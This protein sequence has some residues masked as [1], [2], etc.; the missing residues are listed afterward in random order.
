MLHLEEDFLNQYPVWDRLRATYRK[1]TARELAKLK[2]ES[3]LDLELAGLLLQD[4]GLKEH[5]RVL[6][7][8]QD[9]V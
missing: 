7:S 3:M 1:Y 5:L 4:R 2:Q 8:V 6:Q 9:L